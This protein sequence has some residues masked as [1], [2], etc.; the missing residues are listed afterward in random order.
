MTEYKLNFRGLSHWYT[1]VNQC[2]NKEVKQQNN[3]D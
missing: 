2:N 3:K 1:E